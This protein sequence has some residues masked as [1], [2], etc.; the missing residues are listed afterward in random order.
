MRSTDRGRTWT[1]LGADGPDAA[2][3]P[4]PADA[5]E[6]WLGMAPPYTRE[7]LDAFLA[8]RRP[9]HRIRERTLC[10]SRA[11][12]PVPLLDL[13]PAAGTEEHQIVVTAR[14][15]CCEMQANREI[16]GLIDAACADPWWHRQR[17]LVVPFM[18]C[19]GV[20]AGDQGKNRRPHDHN[21]DYLSGIYPEIRAFRD[22]IGR[23]CDGRLAVTLDLHCPWIRHQWNEHIYQVGAA[24]PAAWQRQQRFS[25]ILAAVARGPLPYHAHRDLPHGQAWNTSAPDGLH[26]G[27]RRWL[28]AQAPAG[29][30]CTTMEFPYA[31]VAGTPVQPGY[32]EAFG[33]DLAMAIRTFLTNPA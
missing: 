25:D 9:T 24:E 29:C 7:H 6:V 28:Q 13:G 14:H 11:G 32:A 4:I 8:S 15:H 5:D 2:T 3:C 22:L 33:R 12:R 26:L 27:C 18:D 21:R 20:E 31:E 17:L 1:W 16:E 19:D 30:L 23:D 10:L